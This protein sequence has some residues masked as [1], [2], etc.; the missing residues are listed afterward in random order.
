MFLI[1]YKKLVKKNIIVSEEGIEPIR[2][3]NYQEQKTWPAP[4]MMKQTMNYTH[5]YIH[6]KRQFWLFWILRL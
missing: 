4:Y 6:L 1:N 2:N 5:N 3:K